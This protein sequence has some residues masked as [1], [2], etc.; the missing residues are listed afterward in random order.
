MIIN[1]LA[2]TKMF[3]IMEGPDNTDAILRGSALATTSGGGTG[4]GGR[5]GADAGGG[6]R[7]GAD[8]G[9]GGRGGADSPQKGG[10]SSIASAE[11]VIHVSLA[12][13]LVA[14]DGTV[15]WITT[16]ESRGANDKGPVEDA[17]N[18][19]VE[20]LKSDLARLPLPPH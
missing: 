16:Q 10:S 7:G 14:T 13:R 12:V 17:V 8:A 4:G 9:G 20:K 19:I 1:Y 15:I 11:T 6:G 5:G 18:S 2:A 3:I